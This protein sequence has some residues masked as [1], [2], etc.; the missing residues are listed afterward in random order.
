MSL[1][2]K[3]RP[4]SLNAQFN[5]IAMWLSFYRT[6]VIF[7]SPDPQCRQ[8]LFQERY[9]HLIIELEYGGSLLKIRFPEC[10]K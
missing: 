1:I 7:C 4:A 3:M 2:F 9:P 10:K 5:Y 8:K 6:K